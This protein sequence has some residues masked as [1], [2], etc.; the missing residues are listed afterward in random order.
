MTEAANGHPVTN[1]DPVKPVQRDSET[2][3]AEANEL[4]KAGN[5]ADAIELY[6]EAFDL[7]QGTN[8]T[9]LLNRAA[10]YLMLRQYN[11]ALQ[12]TQRVLSRDPSNVKAV[13]RC[14]KALC[15][16]GRVEDAERTLREGKKAVDAA[17]AKE[18][19]KE[20]SETEH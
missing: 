17:S 11:E 4:Y 8:Y 6:S 1:G 2:V 12:D 19:E 9:L 20:V 13:I 10:A 3:K 16:L 5:Y 7:S 18:I 14:S 15:G